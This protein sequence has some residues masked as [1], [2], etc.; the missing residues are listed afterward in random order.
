MA[1]GNTE[2]PPELTKTA[3]RVTMASG[4]NQTRK[5]GASQSGQRTNCV[6]TQGQHL[7]DI[8]PRLKSCGSCRDL[9]RL[10]FD[11]TDSAVSIFFRDSIL[12]RT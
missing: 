3:N 5:N 6:T 9:T 7:T 1:T 12:P 8:L 11:D 4:E 2:V 10:E